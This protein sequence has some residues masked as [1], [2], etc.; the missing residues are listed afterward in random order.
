ML[1]SNQPNSNQFGDDP[2]NRIVGAC[3][4][5]SIESGAVVDIYDGCV[6]ALDK[7]DLS[8]HLR[9]VC[10]QRLGAVF[11]QLIESGNRTLLD[12]LQWN[13]GLG[14]PHVASRLQAAQ[15]MSQLLGTPPDSSRSRSL[16]EQVATSC[17]KD[18]FA[19]PLSPSVNALSELESFLKKA[20]AFFDRVI[21]FECSRKRLPKNR[22]LSLSD[23]RFMYRAD[24][25][26]VSNLRLLIGNNMP[27]DVC[28]QISE[29]FLRIGE[30]T[31]R[32]EIIDMWKWF[33]HSSTCSSLLAD[34]RLP[35]PVGRPAL[36]GAIKGHES[37]AMR[38][39]LGGPRVV[40]QFPLS[41]PESPARWRYFAQRVSALQSVKDSSV[42]D[43]RIG[44]YVVSFREYLAAQRFYNREEE[45]FREINLV[46]HASKEARAFYTDVY[47]IDAPPG[48]ENSKSIEAPLRE[49][50]QAFRLLAAARYGLN[51]RKGY[52]RSLIDSNKWLLEHMADEL[53]GGFA[54]YKYRDVDAYP[55]SGARLWG[56]D[57]RNALDLSSPQSRQRWLK[58]CPWIGASLRA[59]GEVE[60]HFTRGFKTIARTLEAATRPLSTEWARNGSYDGEPYTAF[61]FN[62]HF[63]NDLLPEVRMWLVP[64]RVFHRKIMWAIENEVDINTLDITPEGLA[65]DANALQ[66]TILDVGTSCCRWG[67]FANAWPHGKGRAFR[68]ELDSDWCF[69]KWQ[70]P[71][72]VHRGLAGER[73]SEELTAPV[74]RVMA[75]A[76]VEHDKI[77]R[78]VQFFLDLHSSFLTMEEAWAKGYA[79]VDEPPAKEEAAPPADEGAAGGLGGSEGNEPL[80]DGVPRRLRNR[81]LDHFLQLRNQLLGAGALNGDPATNELDIRLE[82]HYTRLFVRQ[83]GSPYLS[84]SDMMVVFPD[85]K[86]I[87]MLG[88][89]PKPGEVV[90]RRLERTERMEALWDQYI[91][92]QFAPNNCP[93]I[94]YP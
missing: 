71:R 40:H 47:G 6:V 59:G 23:I 77:K 84:G 64:E 51:V 92:S 2:R 60:Y 54:R 69:S 68:W 37:P 1:S 73:Y 81:M 85:G 18:I 70:S 13:Q 86:R 58:A 67:S 28:M 66:L 75:A 48:P 82:L 90:T 14:H 46:G 16:R 57:I 55:G 12:E 27:A 61:I 80:Y 53:K 4:L 65:E 91:V 76:R 9:S 21:S 31:L 50:A 45:L 29:A 62:D 88:G 3:L 8:A 36:M 17:L 24:E 63:H 10:H 11:I 56:L 93:R 78:M 41:L 19:S 72:H 7:S 20:P 42:R 32:D 79:N 43:A 25:V 5:K 52:T 33:A 49:T 89:L 39:Y 74:A 26:L 83:E 87:S 34:K 44:A 22:T 30:R 35:E 94:I 38:F 15:L